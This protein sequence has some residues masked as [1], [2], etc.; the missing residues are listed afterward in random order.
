[1]RDYFSLRIEGEIVAESPLATSPPYTPPG[2]STSNP[3]RNPPTPLPRMSIHLDGGGVEL[4]PYFPGG[5][6][7]GRLRRMAEEAVRYGLVGEDAPS[8]FGVEDAYYLR[9]GGVKG[10]EREDKADI[11]SADARRQANPL[12]ALFGAGAPWDYGRLS[13]GHARPSAPIQVDIVRGVRMDDFSR[14]GDALVALAPKARATWLE[15]SRRKSMAARNRQQLRDL[16][17]TARRQKDATEKTRFEAAAEA[18]KTQINLQEAESGADVS[19][20]L[21]LPGYEAIPA[22]TRLTHD[23]TL[24]RVQPHEVGLFLGALERLAWTP[25]I[26]AHTAHGC[27]IVSGLWRVRMRLGEMGRWHNAG[28]LRMKPFDGIELPQVFDGMQAAFIELLK[29]GKFDF[30][31]PRI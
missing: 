6:L 22:G 23:F 19:I 30:R 3:N 20:L 29:G 10:S 26:G 13:V 7:R 27:G 11:L 12:I 18:L 25:M 14:G 17:R 21:P 24:L 2:T 16:E 9:N 15:M 5:G 31:A 28:E 1:M 4:V 8:P